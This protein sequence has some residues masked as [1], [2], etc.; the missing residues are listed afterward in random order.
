MFL[1]RMLISIRHIFN[2]S[3][4]LVNPEGGGGGGALPYAKVGDACRLTEGC[5]SRIPPSF[6]MFMMRRYDFQLSE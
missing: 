5:K 6:R 1:G 4:V 2:F 3:P